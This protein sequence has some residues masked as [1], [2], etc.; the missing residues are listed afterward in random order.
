MAASLSSKSIIK[1]SQK[2]FIS[3]ALFL[4][5]SSC[6]QTTGRQSSIWMLPEQDHGLQQHF[7]RHPIK[8]Y[9]RR[10]CL[11]H[12]LKYCFRL[13]T[14]KNNKKKTLIIFLFIYFSFNWPRKNSLQ[15]CKLPWILFRRWKIFIKKLQFII[16]LFILSFSLEMN[17]RFL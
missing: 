6:D 15:Q 8:R 12:F 16:Y 7:Y 1:H 11:M 2:I 17:A 10:Y 3:S 13:K 4:N 5:G 9:N 14:K